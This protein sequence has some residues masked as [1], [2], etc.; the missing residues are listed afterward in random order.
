MENIMLNKTRNKFIM[1][2][3]TRQNL[4]QTD[5]ATK[6]GTAGVSVKSIA[7][8]MFLIG[9]VFIAIGL[10][11]SFVFG[12]GF[13]DWRVIVPMVLGALTFL[14]ILPATST[15]KRVMAQ[16]VE[17]LEKFKSRHGSVEKVVNEIKDFLR[18][19]ANSADTVT[20]E[21][22]SFHLIGDWF[23]DAATYEVVHTSEIVAIVGIM[24]EGTFLVLDDG[25]TRRVMFGPD[26]WG[27]VF[28]M[29]KNS[30]PYILYSTDEVTLPDGNVIDA[31]TAYTKKEFASITKAYMKNK[32]RQEKIAPFVI[33]ETDDSQSV[34]HYV[35]AFK[36]E[37]FQTRADEGFIGNGYDW[38]SLAEVFI[39]EKMP[40]LATEIEL[41]PEAGMFCAFSTNSDA[42]QKFA[43]EFRAMCNDDKL[44]KDL[45]SRA[46]LA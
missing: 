1:D 43:I 38:A 36:K 3:S 7:A 44:M 32:E 17:Y 4:I 16:Q 18:N 10:A 28:N 9:L 34:C 24:G 21:D 13:S 15:R 27:T 31:R 23:M 41:D 42:L 30:N 11:L 45:F 20:A 5:W 22:S 19:E 39:V 6:V 2:A 25:K 12:E 26:D 35:D 29:F 14:L 40:E 37:I 33:V 46:E 8:T